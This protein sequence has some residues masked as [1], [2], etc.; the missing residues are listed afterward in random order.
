M[1][2]DRWRYR[3]SIGGKGLIERDSERCLHHIESRPVG[4]SLGRYRFSID[5]EGHVREER[6]QAA[7]IGLHR[8]CPVCPLSSLWLPTSPP[9]A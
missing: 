5:V 3:T 4:D 6:V 1:F 7:L 8:T 9:P 2:Y